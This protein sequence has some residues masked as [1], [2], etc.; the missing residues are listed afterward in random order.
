MFSLK[1][2]QHIAAEVEKLLLSLNHPEM[3]KERPEFTLNVRGKEGWS[4]A[5]IGPNWTF[6]PENPHSVNPFNEISRYL[7]REPKHET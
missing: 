1:E 5:E 7:H 2:K 4:W 6:T 3:P